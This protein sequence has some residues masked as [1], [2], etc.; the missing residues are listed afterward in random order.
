MMFECFL[1]SKLLLLGLIKRKFKLFGKGKLI[2]FGYLNYKL[3]IGLSH[4]FLVRRSILPSPGKVTSGRVVHDIWQWRGQKTKA[5]VVYLYAPIQNK[6]NRIYISTTSQIIPNTAV[7]IRRNEGVNFVIQKGSTLVC[8]RHF[9]AADYDDGSATLNTGAVPSRFDWNSYTTAPKKTPVYKRVSAR[10][11]E[12]E[13]KTQTDR[14]GT[15]E[16]D[17]ATRPPAGK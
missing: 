1:N 8:S 6:N 4:N 5:S 13:D 3:A 2:Q 15:G 14:R 9:S 16:H 17:Y 11:A 12:E 7:A 10:K